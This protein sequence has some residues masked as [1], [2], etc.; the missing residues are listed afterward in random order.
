MTRLLV[1]A[2]IAGLLPHLVL[3]A[4]PEQIAEGA[5]IASTTTLGNCAA[6]HN[7]PGAVEAGNVG[8]ELRDMKSLMP[9]RKI[10]YAIIY[11]EP[12][13]NPDTVMPPFGKNKLL[14]P[15]QINDVIDFLYTK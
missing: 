11:N 14:T 9:D 7:Y 12:A 5:K 4:T 3:A 8:P 15:D 6:C 1:V 2:L 10:L 13:N